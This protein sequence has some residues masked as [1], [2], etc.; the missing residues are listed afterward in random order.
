MIL[1]VFTAYFVLFGSLSFDSFCILRNVSWHDL[2]EG[3]F[4]LGM[5]FVNFSSYHRSWS[6]TGNNSYACGI[7]NIKK[8][9]T[10]T[11]AQTLLMA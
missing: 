10:K 3:N 2:W 11:H 1:F 4:I 6:A 7:L 9:T 8:Q 5:F